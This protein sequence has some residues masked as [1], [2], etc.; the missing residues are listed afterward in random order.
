MLKTD[1]I[2][3]LRIANELFVMKRVLKQGFNHFAHNSE[4]QL[5]CFFL[6]QLFTGCF[7]NKKQKTKKTRD[8]V[9]KTL[10]PQ[11]PDSNTA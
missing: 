8:G 2:K 7:K 6:M 4:C 1:F 9:C 3:L 11:L 5:S 10:C